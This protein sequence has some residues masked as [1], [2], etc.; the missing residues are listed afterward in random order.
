MPGNN[1]PIDASLGDPRLMTLES[2]PAT[3]GDIFVDSLN[4]RREEV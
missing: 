3:L 4:F 2:S 1:R